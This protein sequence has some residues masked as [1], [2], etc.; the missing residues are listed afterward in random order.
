MAWTGSPDRSGSW[1]QAGCCAPIDRLEFAAGQAVRESLPGD[2]RGSL[3][4][5]CRLISRLSGIWKQHIQLIA[6]LQGDRGCLA[7]TTL[8]VV[9]MGA[10]HHCIEGARMLVYSQLL[11]GQA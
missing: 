6:A 11:T 7:C 2:S 10:G 3:H 9:H 1:D 4:A 8:E 5:G